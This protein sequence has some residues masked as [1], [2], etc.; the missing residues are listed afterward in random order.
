M[1]LTVYENEYKVEESLKPTFESDEVLVKIKSAGICG[2]DVSRIF[3]KSGKIVISGNVSPRSHLLTAWND[4]PTLS[5]NSLC[6]IPFAFLK[7]AICSPTFSIFI[8]FPPL[9]EFKYII[10]VARKKENNCVIE[11]IAIWLN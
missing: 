3:A 5:P 8:I 11:F 6:V 4:T 7:K 10:T 9:F 2:S 1:K